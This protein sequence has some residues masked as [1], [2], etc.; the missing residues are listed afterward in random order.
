MGKKRKK[1]RATRRD[2]SLGASNEE[3][4]ESSPQESPLGI[5]AQPAQFLEFYADKFAAIQPICWSQRPKEPFFCHGQINTSA[6]SESEPERLL[7]RLERTR[8]QELRQEVHQLDSRLER[9][10]SHRRRIHIRRHSRGNPHRIH[11][12]GSSRTASTSTAGRR[13]T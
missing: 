12:A 3:D 6:V 8:L 7:G 9:H 5:L 10:H 4:E 2:E 13:K 1:H 11:V